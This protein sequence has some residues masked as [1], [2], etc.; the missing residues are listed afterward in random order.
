MVALLKFFFEMALLR[1]APQDLPAS[2]ALLL[3]LLGINFLLSFYIGL[4]VFDS[5]SHALLA[6]WIELSL[7]AGLLLTGLVM[8]D[9][10]QRWQQSYTA[11]L[12]LGV[13]SALLTIFYRLLADA[14]AIPALASTL[15]FTVF[16]WM[17]LALANILRHTFDMALSFGI[18]IVFIYTMLVLSLVARWLPA[19]PAT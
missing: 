13:F 16:L 14:L 10:V 19:G 9:K 8:T 6:N 7:S 17:E 18:L 2:L 11:V 5:T 15:D 4:Q 1:K 12:G 3:V